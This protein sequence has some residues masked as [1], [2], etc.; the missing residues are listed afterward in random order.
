[1]FCTEC[2]APT[3]V[4]RSRRERHIIVR[5]RECEGC[6]ARFTTNEKIAPLAMRTPGKVATSPPAQVHRLSLTV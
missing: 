4:V 3:C 1:M 2:G 5:R 6:G